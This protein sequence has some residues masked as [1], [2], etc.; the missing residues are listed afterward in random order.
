MYINEHLTKKNADIVRQAHFLRKLNKIQS[1]WTSNCKV[2][3]KLNG[4][5]E[6]AKVLIIKDIQELD[7]YQ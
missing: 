5:Q 1:T 4:S 3:I 6:A 7:K 2:F